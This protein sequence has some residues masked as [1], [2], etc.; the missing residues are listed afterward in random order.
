MLHELALKMQNAALR[1]V[2]PYILVKKNVYLDDTLLHIGQYIADLNKFE[3]IFIIGFGKAVA[4]MALPSKKFSNGALP[5]EC[6]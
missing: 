4:P 2:D 1:A 5:A 6:C 3:R